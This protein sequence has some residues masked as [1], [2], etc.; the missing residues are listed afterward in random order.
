LDGPLAARMSKQLHPWRTAAIAAA[1][2]LA[3]GCGGYVAVPDLFHPGPAGYQRARAIQHDPYPLDDVAEPVTG[4][5]PREYERPV[6]APERA[7]Q[8]D[9]RH[10]PTA[11]AAGAPVTF[12]PAPL[13]SPQPAPFGVPPM[14][15]PPAAVGPPPPQS[16]PYQY[17]PPAQPMSAVPPPAPTTAPYQLSVPAA[18]A[19]PAPYPYGATVPVTPPSQFRPPY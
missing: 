15:A 19:Q 9:Q 10:P 3:S 16:L 14:T 2:A 12:A 11:A 8:F 13:A 18:P 17:S 1:I 6:P 5:R 7:V 4:G